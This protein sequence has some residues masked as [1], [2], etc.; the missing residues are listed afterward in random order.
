[1]FDPD[2]W[3]PLPYVVAWVARLGAEGK[4]PRT[5]GFIHPG[6]VAGVLDLSAGDTR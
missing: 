6:D 5:L 1:M 4:L 2:G 3:M